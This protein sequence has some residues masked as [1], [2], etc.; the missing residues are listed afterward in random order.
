MSD[1]T[2]LN[3]VTVGSGDVLSTDDIGG[4]V[5]VQRVKIQQ[6]AD[7]S[8]TDISSA[9]PL[10]VTLANTG[11]NATAVKVDGSA[12]THPV[13]VVSLPLPSGAS[14]A[15]KQPALGVAGTASADVITIQ[16]IASMTAVLVDGSAVTQPVSVASLPLPSGAATAA[17]QPAL[18]VAGTPSADVITVQGTAS[19]T[20]LKVDGSAVTQPVSLASVP[21]HAVTNAGTFAVQ[22]TIASG[23][24]SIAK[25][26]DVASADADVGVPAMAVQRA[27]PADTAGSDL[28]YSMLQMSAGRLWTTAQIDK[29]NGTTVDT[30]SGTKSAGTLR[31]VLATDQPALTNKL[32]TTPDLPSGASTAAKQ[33]ALGVAGTASSDVITIQ[34]IA[35]MTA[36]KVDGSA[37]TQPVSGTVS[38]T[39]NSAVNVAQINGV[40]PSMGNGASGTGVQRVTIA[41]DSTGQVAITG[42]VTVASHAVTN[43]GTFVVQEN[44]T[45]VQ[46]DDAAF[47]PATSKIAVVG[48]LADDTST[49]SV[50]EGDAG[51]A[52][53]TLNRKQI[54]QPYESEA[55]SWNYAAPAAGLVTTTEVSA[56]GAAGAGIR[57]YL[58][59]MQV[60]NSH[61]TTGTEFLVTDGSGGTALFRG[62]VGPLGAATIVFPVPLKSTA[63]TALYIKESSTTASTGVLINLQGYT[64]A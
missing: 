31:V 21:S 3:G 64:G 19:M 16:G 53:M 56:K 37:V 7:G 4:G 11:A 46:V 41:N 23:A 59:S 15:A 12:V 62:F 1:N 5:K 45:W 44:G 40:A 24:T 6:G 52:R 63:N 43:A 30:N 54:T 47:T 42:T 32:L 29:L 61:P 51:A 17:K 55:N 9:A 28:D 38:I 36:V 25:A 8:A 10:Q 35:S 27:S 60:F 14:T 13:S 26:E 2:I 49:D 57:N 22:A 20:A 18:G 33:P 39:A 48:Y 58:T 50:D 34:G